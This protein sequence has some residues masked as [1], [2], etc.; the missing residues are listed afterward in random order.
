MASWHDVQVMDQIQ[1]KRGALLPWEGKRLTA[2][3]KNKLG[4]FRNILHLLLQRDPDERQSV[5]EFCAM[6]ERVVG[7]SITVRPN[8]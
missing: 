7:G 6:C 3:V 1:S 5:T 8:A 2:V 4:V